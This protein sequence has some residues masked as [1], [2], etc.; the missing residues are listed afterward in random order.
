MKDASFRISQ[1]FS[2]IQK[3]TSQLRAL[4]QRGRENWRFSTM[5]HLISDTLSPSCAWSTSGSPFFPFS[6]V[7]CLVADVL[8]C[9][10]HAFNIPPNCVSPSDAQPTS[11]LFVGNPFQ[12]LFC[13]SGVFHP[14]YVSKPAESSLPY[15]DLQHV[16]SSDTF[17]LI[18]AVQFWAVSGHY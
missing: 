5:S 15:N 12:G 2:E 3:V 14:L 16:L 9:H 18:S 13:S 1:A 8:L 17:L 10:V 7:G 4:N 6:S 11:L